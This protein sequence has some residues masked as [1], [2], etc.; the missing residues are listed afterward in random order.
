MDQNDGTVY[1]AGSN[2]SVAV[3]IPPAPGL[4]PVTYTVHPVA[5]TGNAHL[6]FTVKAAR[7]GTVYVCYS[8]DHDVFIRYSKDKGTTWSAAIRVSDGPETKT[9]VFPWME[10]G[11]TPGTI[12]V[13]WYGTTGATNNN[14]DDWYAFYA[15]G[16]NVTS[17]NATFQ[18]AVVSDH[19]IHGA[20]ISAK[21][22]PGVLMDVRYD[23]K[24][25]IDRESFFIKIVNGKAV[26]A[27][28]KPTNALPGRVLS[29][30]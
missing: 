6:F 27:D 30:S 19:V 22:Y 10:T 9:A 14:P 1:L 23:A 24:G 28:S 12:G 20:N 17:S 21:D 2:G 18:Q 16:T 15:L 29:P 25:D 13:V 4:A 8:N 26:V 7:D 11:P 5:G 3:G